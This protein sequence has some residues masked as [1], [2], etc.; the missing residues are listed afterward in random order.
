[1]TWTDYLVNLLRLITGDETATNIKDMPLSTLRQI[2]ELGEARV[3]KEVRT[4]FNEKSFASAIVGGVTA[5][6]EVTNNLAP[7]PDD[8]EACSVLHFGKLPLRPAPEVV[9]IEANNGGSSGEA[10]FFAEAGGSFTFYPA[11]EDGAEVQGR[12]FC[13]LPALGPQTTETNALMTAEPDLFI[14]AA[15]AESGPIFNKFRE[16][17]LWDGLYQRVRDRVNKR[18]GNAAYSAG[19]MSVQPSTRLMR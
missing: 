16:A 9:V 2:I 15:L 10:A 17:P 11:V 14:Y 1:V 8:F 6:L 5:P 18:S 19:R 12:Y 7:I 4:R 13:R 3:Y